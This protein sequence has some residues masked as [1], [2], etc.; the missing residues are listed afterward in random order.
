[1]ISIV[2]S[3]ES[4]DEGEGEG[5]RWPV[6]LFISGKGVYR[7]AIFRRVA[8]KLYDE[9]IAISEEQVSQEERG[10]EYEGH[11][12]KFRLLIWSARC[13]TN[14]WV[15]SARWNQRTGIARRPL[16]GCCQNPLT[17]KR[18]SKDRDWKSTTSRVFSGFL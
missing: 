3:L 2:E 6:V 7:R 12:E 1:M 9:Q 11:C 8:T 14:M 15:Q 4:I 17:Q 16:A 10:K 18:G 13:G 5:T